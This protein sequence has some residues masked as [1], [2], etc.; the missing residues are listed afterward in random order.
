MSTTDTYTLEQLAADCRQA[1]QA[2]SS[3]N[4]L[5]QVRQHL[6]CALKDQG[7]FATHLVAAG[8]ARD[9]IYQD[10]ELGFCIC[11]HV[12]E[13]ENRGKPHDHGPTWAIYGQASGET[14]MT[15]WRVVS[16][17]ENGQPGKVEMVR[18]YWLRPGD[19][20]VYDV[21]DV[22]APWRETAT[23]LLR[24]EGIDTATI[25]RTPLEAIK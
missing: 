5:E 14:E 23:K 11:A 10:A 16:P 18:S 1:L 15:D 6:Q 17:P 13:G 12:Y 2:D 20:H 19:A 24:I 25:K 4:G 7:F 8:K 3:K 9:I 21:S 22:H